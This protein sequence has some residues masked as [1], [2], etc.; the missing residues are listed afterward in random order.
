MPEFQSA[1]ELPC[2]RQEVFDFVRR[3][4]NLITLLASTVQNFEYKLPERLEVG[5][6][7]QFSLHRFGMRIELVHEVVEFVDQERISSTSPGPVPPLVSRIL[8]HGPGTGA[9]S[10]G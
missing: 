4:A 2:P 8:L 9:N 3:P 1:V 10:V 7:L 5:S 6:H